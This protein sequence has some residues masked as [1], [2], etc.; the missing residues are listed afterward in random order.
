MSETYDLYSSVHAIAKSIVTQSKGFGFQSFDAD[1]IHDDVDTAASV[2]KV[3]NDYW[4]AMSL[5]HKAQER[6][7]AARLLDL[8]TRE[9]EDEYERERAVRDELVLQMEEIVGGYEKTYT[10][11]WTKRQ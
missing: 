9:F 7:R 4:E 5:A 8:D 11:G 2:A 10:R 3:A 1:K 6:L